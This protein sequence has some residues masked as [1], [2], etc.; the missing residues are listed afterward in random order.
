MHYHSCENEFN[1]HVNE[2]SFSYMKGWSPRLVLRKRLKVIRKWPRLLESF[3]NAN[4]TLKQLK[5]YATVQSSGKGTSAKTL[6]CVLIVNGG[7][8]EISNKKKGIR[9][10]AI[11]L[12]WLE[13][14]SSTFQEFDGSL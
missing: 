14:V 7:E 5:T 11:R 3:A 13:T 10:Q 8:L 1:L 4:N 6:V 2:I 12:R 9:A